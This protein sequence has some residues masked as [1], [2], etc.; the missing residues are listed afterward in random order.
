MINRLLTLPLSKDNFNKEIN[1]IKTIATNN[2]YDKKLI[3]TLINKKQKKLIHG[4]RLGR[5]IC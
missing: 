3:D 4:Q 2:S 5:N 1:I